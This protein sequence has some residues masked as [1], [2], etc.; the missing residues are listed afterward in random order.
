M[1]S[2]TLC[3]VSLWVLFEFTTVVF[4]ILGLNSVL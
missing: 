4:M 3:G 1:V 2:V